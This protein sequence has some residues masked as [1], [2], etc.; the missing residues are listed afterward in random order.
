MINQ[1]IFSQVGD[2][3]IHESVATFTALLISRRSLSL[4]D[5]IYHVALSSLKAALPGN[6]DVD[7][8]NN[9]YRELR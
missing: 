2:L 1:K 8:N 7:N 5:V 6:E 9:L 3:S 4:E